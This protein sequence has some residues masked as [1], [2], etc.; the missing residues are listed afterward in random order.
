MSAPVPHSAFNLPPSIFPPPTLIKG[1]CI[2]VSGVLFSSLGV[3]TKALCTAH[4]TIQI[5][6]H[7]V[8][9]S[10]SEY[11]KY[12]HYCL[13]LR[14]NGDAGNVLQGQ[15]SKKL[16][17]AIALRIPIFSVTQW[18][19]HVDQFMNNKKTKVST[20]PIP[21]VPIP[22]S[23]ISPSSSVS[24]SIVTQF[25]NLTNNGISVGQ[26]TPISIITKPIT[27]AANA[28]SS[29]AQMS[30]GLKQVACQ[31]VKQNKNLAKGCACGSCY[32]DA[33]STEEAERRNTN[34]SSSISNPIPNLIGSNS[35]ILVSAQ[36]FEGLNMF[37]IPAVFRTPP[38]ALLMPPDIATVNIVPI[39]D[40]Y[41]IEGIS[42][43]VHILIGSDL[44]VDDLFPSRWCLSDE[45]FLSQVLEELESNPTSS[46]STCSSSSACVNDDEDVGVVLRLG[47]ALRTAN[48]S[49]DGILN[50]IELQ[51]LC[52]LFDDANVRELRPCSATIM[53]QLADLD[54]GGRA[55][56]ALCSGL[57]RENRVVELIRIARYLTSSQRFLTLGAHEKSTLY[58]SFPTVSCHR[59]LHQMW[60]CSGLLPQLTAFVLSKREA[61]HAS[62]RHRDL[63]W[64]AFFLMHAPFDREGS[65]QLGTT[66]W[67]DLIPLMDAMHSTG[68]HRRAWERLENHLFVY[69]LQRMDIEALLSPALHTRRLRWF[70]EQASSTLMQA[71]QLPAS[72]SQKTPIVPTDHSDVFASSSPPPSLASPRS[73][74]SVSS[75]GIFARAPN[76]CLQA[77][78]RESNY[79]ALRC[80][81]SAVSATP[82]DHISHSD[83]HYLMFLCKR[84]MN[85]FVNTQ[86]MLQ[87]FHA[88]PPPTSA[89]SFYVHTICTHVTPVVTNSSVG[90]SSLVSPTIAYI[91]A[92]A[93]QT[94]QV[95]VQLGKLT[96]HPF[97]DNWV[98]FQGEMTAILQE[99]VDTFAASLVLGTPIKDDTP[100]PPP[101]TIEQEWAVRKNEFGALG[102]AYP[103]MDTLLS[104]IGLHNIKREF[105]RIY[106]FVQ[107]QKKRG[108]S[109]LRD[110][111]HVRMVG[112]SGVGKSAVAKL[113]ATFLGHLG[114]RTGIHTH[115]IDGQRMVD[116]GVQDGY[117]DPLKAF[118][119]SCRGGTVILDHAGSLDPVGQPAGRSIMH[120]IN[121]DME[122]KANELTFV[123]LGSGK[124]LDGLFG[125]SSSL[126]NRVQTHWVL[127]DYTEPELRLLFI[128]LLKNRDARFEVE[129]GATGLALQIVCRRLAAQRGPDF[130]NAHSVVHQINLILRRQAER[131][132]NVQ[133]HLKK[134]PASASVRPAARPVSKSKSSA[135]TASAASA[136]PSAAIAPNMFL[137]SFDDMVGPNPFT[138]LETSAS[139]KQL[140]G[141]VGLRQVKKEIQQIIQAVRENYQR[142]LRM[143]E[144]TDLALNR[145]FLGN[146]GTGTC[147]FNKTV[148]VL[149][150]LL[151]A[152]VNI[153]S[154]HNSHCCC[155]LCVICCSSVSFHNQAKR[156][157]PSCMARSFATWVYCREASTSFVVRP[158]LSVQLL[159]KA[160][161][162]PMPCSWV[163]RVVFWLL[164]RHIVSIPVETAI[165]SARRPSMPSSRRCN[166]QAMQIAWFSC[167][168]TRNLWQQCSGMQILDWHVVS[169]GRT[170]WCLR[171]SRMMNF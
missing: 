105:L 168:D 15:M 129:G 10:D 50:E 98:R 32:E 154:F 115:E 117:I 65:L 23:S 29:S 73:S 21:T 155:C 19:N 62:E 49:E 166:R 36:N 107:M 133:Q 104:M 83:V 3:H 55:W 161:R 18:S 156:Q 101:P 113:Y 109:L 128:H 125:Y 150:V 163:P 97:G 2:A 146:P 1:A 42:V 4:T 99:H 136:P 138:A 126:N 141:M 31:P 39:P 106:D 108:I 91:L 114:V 131:L 171:T 28:T 93:A 170:P 9:A 111:F 124:E 132:H 25:I 8:V 70:G 67:E 122:K 118:L 112:N 53:Y 41:C 142:E 152:S 90:S 84:N 137:L 37:T 119:Q 51:Q 58:L 13:A 121:V 160:R 26:F 96:E 72:F 76:S 164:M 145:V 52:N 130:G 158:T 151:F 57:V 12:E 123:F 6:T 88:L 78:F 95:V 74:S 64:I 30:V 56:S 110:D 127:D 149:L 89:F 35:M 69:W 159:A 63:H 144:K 80:L 33:L 120:A 94:A 139:Y 153:H 43:E 169:I 79:G 85:L 34:L 102:Y 61:P 54:S 140:M 116:D 60:Q 77:F 40:H 27:S 66:R 86:D 59:V 20:V 47:T 7:Y 100:L 38:M 17:A 46:V 82:K 5:T 147:L 167:L 22:P 14:G 44:V 45:W 157:W 24:F 87:E 134:K 162:R 165:H 92:F 103:S 75:V 16:R 148:W 48:V 11:E 81:Q 143:E 68:M 135:S 71:V